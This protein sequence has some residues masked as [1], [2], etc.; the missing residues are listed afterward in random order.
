[1]V[2][3]CSGF[4]FALFFFTAEYAEEKLSWF[5]SER[6]MEYWRYGVME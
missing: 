6:R 4:L 1:M 3:Y 5:W 2:F